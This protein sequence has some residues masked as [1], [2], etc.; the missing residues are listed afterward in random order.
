MLDVRF[1]SGWRILG[2]V[3]IKIEWIILIAFRSSSRS[4]L[5]GGPTGG[6]VG[7]AADGGAD[8]GLKRFIEPLAL[9]SLSK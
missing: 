2:F 8:E 6:E 4:P 9:Y 1:P 5:A 3:A 7:A